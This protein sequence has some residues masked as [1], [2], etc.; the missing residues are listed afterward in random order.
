MERIS[1]HSCFFIIKHSVADDGRVI[2][3]EVTSFMKKQHNINNMYREITTF[4]SEKIRLSKDHLIY[5]RK[6]NSE[7]FNVM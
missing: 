5:G 1:L 6:D 3:S 2:Y 7:K 4:S